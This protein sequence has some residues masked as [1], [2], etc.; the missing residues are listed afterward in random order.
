MLF[1]RDATESFGF[2]PLINE[3]HSESES[4][5]LLAPTGDFLSSE[6]VTGRDD[7]TV[8]I[9][10]LGMT[11]QSCVKNIEEN[12][13]KKPG[14]YS[15]KVSLQEK[16]A[17]VHYDTTQLKTVQI[18]DYIEDMGFEAT[19]PQS[20]YL[21]NRECKVHIDG[22][23][24]KSCVQSIEGKFNFQLSLTSCSCSSFDRNYSQ[25]VF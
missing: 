11:C 1:F 24:C 20:E 19:P 8:K 23:T 14:I 7:A 16:V 4:V 22:M 3:K 25:Y 21:T 17:S 13:S 2:E 18:C 5:S 15:I 12:L 6:P 9:S 10:V